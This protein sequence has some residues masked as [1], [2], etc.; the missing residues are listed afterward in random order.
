MNHNDAVIWL[1]FIHG[2]EDCYLGIF[3]TLRK[4]TEPF[5]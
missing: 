5:I 1:I 4:N 3:T 2:V